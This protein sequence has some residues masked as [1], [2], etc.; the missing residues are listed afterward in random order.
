MANEVREVSNLDALEIGEDGRKASRRFIIDADNKLHAEKLLRQQGVRRGSIFEDYSGNRP[1]ST[2]RCYNISIAP[3]ADREI[4]G[5]GGSYTA[6][7]RYRPITQT[8]AS[9]S[10]STAIMELTPDGEAIYYTERSHTTSMVDTDRYGD[11]ILNTA[12]VPFDTPFEIPKVEEIVVFEWIK[13]RTTM[14][15]A[16]TFSRQFLAKTNSTTWQGAEARELLCLGLMPKA[17]DMDCYTNRGGLVKYTAR[18]Q[19]RDTR[20]IRGQEV[21]GYTEARLSMGRSQKNA[22]YDS[23][24]P[25]S[26]PVIPIIIG[27]IDDEDRHQAENPMP[28]DSDGYWIKDI[29]TTDE[30][31]QPALQTFETIEEVDYSTMGIIINGSTS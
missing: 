20:T 9:R 6:I 4:V 23:N 12:G 26:P 17:L 29:D 28:L 10:G 7:A 11:A 18:I 25:E 13:S 1:D 30:N 5:G 3:F 8:D 31:K 2:M 15:S 21:P 16:I 14:L 24:D 27:D 19:W 22:S